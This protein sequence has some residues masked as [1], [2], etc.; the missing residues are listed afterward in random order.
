MILNQNATLM[1]QSKPDAPLGKIV[2]S[3]IKCG[4]MCHGL[5]PHQAKLWLIPL[6]FPSLPTLFCPKNANFALFMQFL[7]DLAKSLPNS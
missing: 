5:T 6:R 3:E 2:P 7:A 1:H 4:C